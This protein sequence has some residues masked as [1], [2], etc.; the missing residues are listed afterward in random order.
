MVAAAED[1][2]AEVE[3]DEDLTYCRRA[4]AGCMHCVAVEATAAGYLEVP[5]VQ[6][7]GALLLA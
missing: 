7:K 6:G 4:G 1:G 3:V 5:F 2:T